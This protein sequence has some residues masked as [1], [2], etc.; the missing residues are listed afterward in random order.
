MLFVILYMI[1]RYYG[2][3]LLSHYYSEFKNDL[4]RD[5]DTEYSDTLQ[6]AVENIPCYNIDKGVPIITKKILQQYSC[7]NKHIIP[8]LYTKNMS[9][10]SWSDQKENKSNF[11]SMLVAFFQF[12]CFNKYAIAITTGGTSGNSFYYWYNKSDTGELLK[13]YLQCWEAFNWDPSKKVLVYYGHPSSGASFIKYFSFCNVNTLIPSFHEG[14][15]TESSVMELL[16]TIEQTRPHILESMPNFMFRVAQYIYCKG[17]VLK[18]KLRGLSLSGDFIFR[19]QYD[20]IRRIFGPETTV[21]MSYGAVEFGQIAQQD[22]VEDLYTYRIFDKYAQ[23]ENV[24]DTLAITR[25]RYKNMPI[26]RYLID[27]CGV[28][29]SDKKYITNLIGKKKTGIDLLGLNNAVE[30]LKCP[31]IIN[32]R[33]RG[34]SLIL[35]TVSIIQDYMLTKLANRTGYT[36]ETI[37]CDS[38]FCP[39]YDNLEGKV[40]PLLD[41]RK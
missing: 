23:V 10:N 5:P 37:L 27:D 30:E 29:S 39:T 25:F 41:D 15:I 2:A 16:A 24:G 17:I 40:T 3:S 34:T 38:T 18:H 8:L 32:I 7:I 33:I 31:D 21:L 35:F 6:S 19:C 28:V 11:F 36:I 20:F 12:L 9:T 22:S 13:S 14:D 26:I 4:L 1:L